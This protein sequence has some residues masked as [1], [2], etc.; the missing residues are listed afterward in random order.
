[1][2]MRATMKKISPTRLM[3]R[4]RRFAP[5]YFSD[6]SG[7]VLGDEERAAETIRIK[8]QKLK[9]LLESRIEVSHAQPLR[10][11]ADRE[12]NSKGQNGDRMCWKK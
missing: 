1:M 12:I 10:R 9:D 2:G 4:T 3:E 8:N 6:R 5:R 7:R 11:K